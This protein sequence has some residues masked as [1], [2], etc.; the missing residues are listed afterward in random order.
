MG[1]CETVRLRANRRVA[2]SLQA[3]SNRLQE[4]ATEDQKRMPVAQPRPK[5]PPLPP[6]APQNTPH[7]ES[8]MAAAVP[9][10]M[11]RKRGE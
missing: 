4:F 11:A 3:F 8:A 10:R 5:P 7:P 9:S 2:S 6:A 1:Q